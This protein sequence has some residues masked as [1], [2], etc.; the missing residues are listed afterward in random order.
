M[1]EHSWNILSNQ[2]IYSFIQ[3][4]RIK[5][6]FLDYFKIVEHFK[7]MGHLYENLPTFQRICAQIKGNIAIFFRRFNQIFQKL[8][9]WK[10]YSLENTSTIFV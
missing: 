8:N 5:Y 9:Y 3:S 2:N 7:V 1:M 6:Y 10:E 4:S